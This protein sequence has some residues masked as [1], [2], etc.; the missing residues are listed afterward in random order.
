MLAIGALPACGGGGDVWFSHYRSTQPAPP[1]PAPAPAPA[2]IGLRWS[3]PTT[4]PGSVLPVAGDD[5]VIP[6]GV[7]IIWDVPSTPELNSLDIQGTLD[8]DPALDLGLTSKSITGTG[9]AWLLGRSDAVYTKNATITLTGLKGSAT[10]T[11]VVNTDGGGLNRGIVFTN[12]RW[13]FYGKAPTFDRTFLNADAAAGASALTLQDAVG[14]PAGTNIAI[15]PTKY[16]G[17]SVTEQH[18]LSA[19]TSGTSAALL[20]SLVTGR[21]G[22]KQYPVEITA[23]VTIG[24][25]SP[26]VC[27]WTG[28]PLVANQPVKFTSNGTLTTGLIDDV[29]YYFVRGASITTNTFEFS[30][31]PG[32]AAIGGLTGGIGTITAHTGGISF[33]P[34]TFSSMRATAD[35]ANEIDQRALIVN[36]DRNII[37]QAPNDSEWLTKGFGVHTMVMDTAGTGITKLKNIGI[38]R[39]GQNGM[40]GRY[41]IHL[42]MLSYTEATWNGSAFVGGGAFTNE[43]TNHVI[44]GCSVWQ[45]SFR[46]ITVHGTCGATVKNNVCFDIGGNAIFL[47]DH[48]ERRNVIDGNVVLKVR[49]PVTRIKNFDQS[50]SGNAVSFP[51]GS[52][53]FWLTNANNYVRNNHAADCQGNGFD[54]VFQSLTCLGLCTNVAVAPIYMP[55]LEH[56]NNTSHSNQGAAMMTRTGIQNDAGTTTDGAVWAPTDTGL[57]GGT[58]QIAQITQFKGWKNASLGYGNAV[59][60]V[61]YDRWTFGDNHEMNIVGAV[62]DNSRI[63]NALH[64]GRSLNT[65]TNPLG[66]SN[67]PLTAAASYHETGN[68]IDSTFV[69]FPWVDYYDPAPSEVNITRMGG[70]AIRSQ[71]LYLV[72]M[73]KGYK[74]N[75]NLKFLA[76]HPGFIVRPPHIDGRTNITGGDKRQWTLAGARWDFNG[77]FGPAGNYIV[78]N[79]TFLTYGLSTSQEVHPIGGN[80]GYSTPDVFFGVQPYVSDENPVLDFTY[81]ARIKVDQ[82]DSGGTIQGTWDVP[83]AVVGSGSTFGFR[84]FAARKTGRYIMHTPGAAPNTA[85]VQVEISGLINSGDF[86]YLAFDWDGTIPA[87][88]WQKVY[89]SSAYFAAGEGDTDRLIATS[90]AN[91]AALEASTDGK[92]YFQDTANNLFWV[93]IYGGLRWWPFTLVTDTDY[94]LYRGQF[95]A[96]V[97]QTAF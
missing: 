82:V 59:R 19:P 28:H 56:T 61:I 13:E 55:L 6:S 66:E 52:S 14:W 15:A 1:A 26:A 75:V 74:R 81:S 63:T 83:E 77:Y 31:K 34:G 53:G 94:D 30:H 17:E 39:G 64:Y 93:K 8:G 5:I 48:A 29:R 25:G 24:A 45:S 60:T 7:V 20:G 88:A 72:P 4:W 91:M 80:Q 54:N 36:L 16:Y 44:E 68:Y 67:F 97:P 69:G 84:H 90:S 46:G 42:H 9:G 89:T 32:G 86:I 37:I 43:A 51:R 85:K 2:P 12:F 11:S 10:S 58:P 95:L 18:T 87:K 73:D 23:T 96:V 33:T 78:H 65:G 47:E 41:P 62:G 71:D 57:V 76:S 35:V 22:R 92:H 27:G 21:L 38:R 40:L 49:D 79:D 70:G 50:F 3:N